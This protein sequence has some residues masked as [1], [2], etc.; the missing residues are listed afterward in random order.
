MIVCACVKASFCTETEKIKFRQPQACKFECSSK[1]NNDDGKEA[2]TTGIKNITKAQKFLRSI[3]DSQGEKMF[4]KNNEES[5]SYLARA[6]NKMP[7]KGC[8]VEY[9]T[10]VIASNHQPTTRL[11]EYPLP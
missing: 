4:E 1:I 11:L 9:E 3:A 10:P 7:E 8:R 6:V 5:I 2:N